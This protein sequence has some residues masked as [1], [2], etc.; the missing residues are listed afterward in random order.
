M[1]TKGYKRVSTTHNGQTVW[2]YAKP[3]SDG[4]AELSKA[5]AKL[6]RKASKGAKKSE[7]QDNSLDA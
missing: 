5:T 2:V 7:S 4:T 6:D 3:G 1:S